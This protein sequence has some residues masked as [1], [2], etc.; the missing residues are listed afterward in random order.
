[1]T[2]GGDEPA[3]VS[4][5]SSGSMKPTNASTVTHTL[6]CQK[7]RAMTARH[8]DTVTPAASATAGRMASA[9]ATIAAHV[10]AP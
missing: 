1:M 5:A 4:Q 9:A 7:F 8:C 2:H 3:I 6:S 10:G